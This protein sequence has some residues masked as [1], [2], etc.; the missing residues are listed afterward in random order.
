M[1]SRTRP[2]LLVLAIALA[3][4]T[5]FGVR[6]RHDPSAD[7]TRLHTFAWLPL[8]EAQPADQRVL[9]HLIDERLRTAV[10]RELRAKGLAPAVGAAPDVLLN[11]RLTSSPDSDR[12]GNR[13]RFDRSAGWWGGW[14]GSESIYESYDAGALFLAMVD[15][16][17]KRVIWIGAA[18]ARLLPHIS[19][20]KRLERADAAVHHIVERFPE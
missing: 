16:A 2:L 18:Q 14:A 10:A 19:F 20:E 8:S 7:F 1:R 15:P 17:T 9:D 4:C 13:A 11:Y 3:G 6:T 5:R 12:G